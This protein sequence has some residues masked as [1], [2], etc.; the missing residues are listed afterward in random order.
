MLG[1]CT[2]MP[3]DRNEQNV[4]LLR[5]WKSWEKNFIA[6]IVKQQK[7]TTL[8]QEAVWGEIGSLWKVL[9]M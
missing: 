1:K 7:K 3:E 4:H 6:D 8:Y 5:Q 2:F 9:S